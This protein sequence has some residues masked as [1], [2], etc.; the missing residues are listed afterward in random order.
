MLT[1][2]YFERSMS[3][4]SLLIMAGNTQRI[5]TDYVQ[6]ID[7]SCLRPR[8]LSANVTS[9]FN[10]FLLSLAN[11]TVTVCTASIFN[12]LQSFLPIVK[13]FTETAGSPE[14]AE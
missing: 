2:D 13:T 11:L 6:F 10:S 5:S 8:L 3:G 12:P 1:V 7:F 14:A 4:H 9:R